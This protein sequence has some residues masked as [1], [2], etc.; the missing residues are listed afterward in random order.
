M[1]LSRED[2]PAPFGPMIAWILPEATDMS[3]SASAVTPPNFRVRSDTR[4]SG[5]SGGIELP[6]SECLYARVRKGGSSQIRAGATRRA[7]PHPL[8]TPVTRYDHTTFPL[9]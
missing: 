5:C 3:T 7:P 6:F 4:S 1:Q 2:F 9:C 8:V